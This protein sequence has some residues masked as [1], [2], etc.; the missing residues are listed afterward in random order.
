MKPIKLGR[1]DDPYGDRTDPRKAAVLEEI[2]KQ[3]DADA[4]RAFKKIQPA[5][6]ELVRQVREQGSSKN[7]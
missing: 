4:E 6:R 2:H 3:A 1:V 7:G 5:L